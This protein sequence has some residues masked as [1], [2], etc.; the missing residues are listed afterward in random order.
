MDAWCKFIG[1]RF[2]NSYKNEF[3]V[4]LLK[5]FRSDFRQNSLNVVMDT[6]PK[7]TCLPA[8]K[9]RTYFNAG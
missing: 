2:E 4:L 5:V 8:A 7:P 6:T 3:E 9:L 1:S